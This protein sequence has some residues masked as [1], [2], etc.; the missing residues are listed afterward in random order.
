MRNRNNQIAVVNLQPDLSRGSVTRTIR[1]GNFDVPTTVARI[2]DRLY[3]V[4]ARFGTTPSNST[5][6]W[7]A[8]VAR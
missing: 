8:R 7:I 3:A 1:S 5:R 4:N 2:G 6:Y